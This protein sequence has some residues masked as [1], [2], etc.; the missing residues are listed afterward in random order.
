MEEGEFSERNK[1]RINLRH[2]ESDGGGR[3]MVKE[4][5]EYRLRHR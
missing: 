3:V 5:K 1:E 4:E 2:R